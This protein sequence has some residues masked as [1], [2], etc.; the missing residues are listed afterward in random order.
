MTPADHVA[1]SNHAR[2]TANLLA[3]G[4]NP[5]AS[6]LYFYA[7]YSAARAAFLRD[8]RL[9][10]DDS[11]R[12]VHPKLLASSRGVDF[13]KGH[14]SRGPGVND[15]V[16]YMYPAIGT[17]YQLLHI[18]SVEVRYAKG[19]TGSTI[20]DSRDLADAVIDE[21]TRLGLYP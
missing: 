11:A 17:R 14:P 6:V 3:R 2:N 1:R 19:L 15:M 13:H 4:N 7:A 10:T 8:A 18:Q 21:F 20:H 9:A 16:Q 5:W 12:E